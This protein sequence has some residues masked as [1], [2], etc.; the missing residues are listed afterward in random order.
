MNCRAFEER[1]N[2]LL[3]ERSFPQ[4]DA[5]LQ[6][7]AQDCGNCRQVLHAQ[8]RLLSGL[9]LFEPPPLSVNFTDQVLAE[10]AHSGESSPTTPARRWNRL[11]LAGWATVA[12][13][14][15]VVVS[16]A[17]QAGPDLGVTQSDRPAA[18]NNA[19]NPLAGTQAMA[20]GH[21]S[22]LPHKDAVRR[23]PTSL[24]NPGGVRYREYREAIHGLAMRLPD[25]VEQLETV[26]AYA[27]GIRPVRASFSVAIDAL[28]RTLPGSSDDRPGI[29]QAG[30]PQSSSQATA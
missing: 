28:R 26:E 9:E 24:D 13:I 27:P 18:P 5:L 30:L 7:H 10:W 29:P 15:L 6:S 14:L 21:S 11:A 20:S 23:L 8:A 12:A 19:Q 16:L 17:F 4:H 3:D 2:L 1:L 25:A 22:T